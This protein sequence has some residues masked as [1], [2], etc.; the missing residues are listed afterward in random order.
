MADLLRSAGLEPAL[1]AR[2]SGRPNLIARLRGR[3][4]SPPLLLYGHVDVV[5]A[6]GNEWTH[7]PFSGA[8]VDGEVWGRG[9]LD[10]KGGVA[11]FVA[12]V[13]RAAQERLEPSGDVIL[14]L[15]SDEEAGSEAG[16][17]FLVQQ[18]SGLF[19][20]VRFALGEFGAFRHW[21]A[22]RTLYPIQVAEKQRCVV[23]A[24]TRGNG[25]H[26]ATVV[27]DT[28]AEKAARLLTVLAR[29]RLPV[30]IT[31]PARLMI[32]AMASALPR[33]QRMA[34]RLLLVP[35]LTDR[36]LNVVGREG[37]SLD[38]LLH[39]TATPTVIRGGGSTNVVPTDVEVDLDGRTLPGQGPRDLVRELRHLAGELADLEIVREEPAPRVDPDLTL[40]PLLADVL[41]ERDPDG[42]P[43]PA[44]L[45]GY[46]DARYFA[47]LGIQTYGFLPMPLPKHI[48][49]ALIHAPDERVPA[50]AIEFGADAVYEVIR[51]YRV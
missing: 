33:A 39:N 1:H 2:D 9:A 22:G 37:D 49:T 48:T 6:D 7:P 46:T 21:A 45:P 35:R 50:E 32:E 47:Q 5:P 28:A 44:L 23:R 15:L 25:G 19:D 3:G 40:F 10:M 4:E 41:R 30:H 43:I 31:P 11:M 42:T 18:R 13:L 29:R 27:H 36:V 51:R 20:E 24:T 14:A 8:L 34:L 17:A 16:A 12:A 26:A 38:P